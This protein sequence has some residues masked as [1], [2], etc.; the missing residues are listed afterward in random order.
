MRKIISVM[1]LTSAIMLA[2]GPVASAVETDDSTAPLSTDEVRMI[3]QDMPGPAGGPEMAWADRDRH[4]ERAEWREGQ[5]CDMQPPA[6][7]MRDRWQRRRG[8]EMPDGRRMGRREWGRG[9]RPEM[10]E[11]VQAEQIEKLMDFLTEH[12]P[13]LAVVLKEFRDE[14]PEMFE[15]KVPGL[16][17][18][19][20]P[21]MEQM[22][23]NPEVAELGLKRIRLKLRVDQAVRQFKQAGKDDQPAAKKELRKRVADMYEV[24]LEETEM[25]IDRFA[26][27]IAKA[28][29]WRDI[30]SEKG[31][32]PDKEEC[33]RED[34]ER[35]RKH[36]DRDERFQHHRVK[37]MEAMS[38]KL[39]DSRENLRT[40]RENRKQIIDQR[41]EQ[42]TVGVKEFPWGK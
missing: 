25:K 6:E 16:L 23:R 40:W 11:G 8:E 18:I 14:N 5:D 42:L 4:P 26:E 24:I 7:K 12:E 10:D 22:E 3:Q 31:E 41:V 15:R 37:R 9:P 2:C 39:D 20:G 29:Q 21:L 32:E 38:R 33:S 30:L 13:S 28:K 34:G 19:Y 35:A 1:I 27:E 36:R 17:R